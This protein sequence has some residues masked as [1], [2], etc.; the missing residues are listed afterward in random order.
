MLRGVHRARCGFLARCTSDLVILQSQSSE[1]IILAGRRGGR[2]LNE[3]EW[4]LGIREFLILCPASC[5][6]HDEQDSGDDRSVGKS[7]PLR[8]SESGT[9]HHHNGVFSNL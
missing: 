8:S 7:P 5:M 3:L 6:P 1:E 4:V 2:R 9:V